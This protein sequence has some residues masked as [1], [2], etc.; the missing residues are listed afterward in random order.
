MARPTNFS[1]L[2]LMVAR[3]RHLIVPLA[4]ITL[5]IVLLVPL[6]PPVLDVL[7]SMNIWL[8]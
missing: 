1:D 4:F 2:L 6:P 7:L 8:A 5:I 3:Y